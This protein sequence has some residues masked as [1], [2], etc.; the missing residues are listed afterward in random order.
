MIDYDPKE[1]HGWAE[2]NP[3]SAFHQFP[4]LA[5]RLIRAPVPTTSFISMSEGVPHGIS[6][7][8]GAYE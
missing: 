6:I 1:I 5:R 2:K 8:E 7:P 3:T 4:K